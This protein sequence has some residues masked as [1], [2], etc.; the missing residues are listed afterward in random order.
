MITTPQEYYAKLH[1]I[2]DT[3]KPS[4]AVLA[5]NTEKIYNIDL[6]TRKIDS[7]EFLS[8]EKDH[9][10]ETI[11]FMV[12]RVYDSIDLAETTCIIQYINAKKEARIYAV[13]FYDITTINGKII[14]PWCIEG[15]ATKASGTVKY[16]FKF[17]STFKDEE[18]QI[19]FDFNLNTLP[20][21]SKVLSGLDVA[22]DDE[23]YDYIAS[24]IESALARVDVA[25][26]LDIE[27]IHL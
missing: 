15:E 18:D 27:W 8:I 20:A 3:N 23:T 10:A 24:E 22:K 16:S 11:Y 4:I 13:P 17:Y 2:Q 21:N 12:D 26:K 1:L 19:L 6:N 7:P 9:M 5:P 14:I 25:T